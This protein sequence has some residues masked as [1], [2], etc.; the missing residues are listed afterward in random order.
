MVFLDNNTL[1][2]IEASA[3]HLSCRAS[4]THI[5]NPR[6]KVNILHPCRKQ[7]LRENQEMS[8]ET[9]KNVELMAEG[10]SMKQQQRGCLRSCKLQLII[11]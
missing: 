10:K 2:L 6:V 3:E 9:K 7:Y 5:F 4:D 11:D 8:V 1:T